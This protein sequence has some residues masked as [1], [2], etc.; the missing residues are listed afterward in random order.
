MNVNLKKIGKTVRELRGEMSLREFAKRCEISH[1][2][3][4]NIEKGI[5]FRTGKPAQI[6]ID[7]LMKIAS[8]CNVSLI[9]IIGEEFSNNEL[10]NSPIPDDVVIYRRNGN[11][12]K[13]KFSKKQLDL[14]YAMIDATSDTTD[15]T[16]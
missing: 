13:Q 12:I 16:L 1:T 7:T 11:T 10:E 4:D 6:K 14:F 9:S 8:A 15:K 5:D 3:I 2:T